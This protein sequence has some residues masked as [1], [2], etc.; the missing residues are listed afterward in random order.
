M[1]YYTF[2]SCVPGKYNE[3]FCPIN[4]TS[5]KIRWQIK[6]IEGKCKIKVLDRE[7]F[8]EINNCKIY[9]PDTY[10]DI[11][12]E[13]ENF[14]YDFEKDVRHVCEV[15]IDIDNGG[16]YTFYSSK[17]FTITNCS[18]Y[19]KQVLGLYNYELPL[20]AERF[21]EKYYI[22]L[23]TAGY[24]LASSMWFG[25]C[26][27][28]SPCVITRANNQWFSTVCFRLFNNYKQDQSIDYTNNEFSNISSN[29]KNLHIQI[30]D[31]NLKPVRF[32]S[33]IH[34]YMEVERLDDEDHSDRALLE[35][36]PTDEE[37]K[38]K[39][40]KL[41]QKFY[42]HRKKN[43]EYVRDFD[44]TK[45]RINEDQPFFNIKQIEEFVKNH[46]EQPSEQTAQTDDTPEEANQ[47]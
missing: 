28:G 27:E 34:L 23:E 6:K 30:I 22:D 47:I 37:F 5:N 29:I 40:E 35:N 24:K 1:E 46:I 39:R 13:K 21:G 38:N 31:E 33:P 2:S 19:L 36:L 3:I 10:Y 12:E 44:I 25:V 8:I 14:L 41:S 18:Y 16:C 43:F 45:E 15:E 7:D 9:V 17:P 4:T 26:S 20:N 32:I 11:D 42:E